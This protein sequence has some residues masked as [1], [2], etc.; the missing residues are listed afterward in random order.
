MFFT[1]HGKCY[2]V[3]VHEIP[4]GGR[5]AKGRHA[6]NMIKLDD[7]ESICAFQP[8]RRFEEGYYVVMGTRNGTIKKTELT[9][10]SN[11]RRDGIKAIGITPGEDELI[12]ASIT[13]GSNEVVLATRHGKAIRFPENK[14]RSMGRVAY[15][16]KGIN[17]EEDDYVV[18]MVVIKRSSW[19][20]T[21]TEN[22]Y[23]KRSSVDD[24]RITNR[25]GKGII[26]IKTSERNGEVVAVKEVVETDELMIITQH[27]I[28]IRTPIKQIRS[29]GRATQGVKLINLDEGDLVI[30]VARVVTDRNGAEEENG[31][32]L[33][34]SPEE[35]EAE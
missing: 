17:L 15:G 34:D 1:S 29:I 20:L 10:F 26:N 13:D 27:G 12:D 23:G 32:A 25:G 33:S 7:G 9:A 35:A 3:K 19:L 16:V 14:V 8:V 28:I 21:V 5:L 18:S 11:P 2:W 22:G 31:E 24:Y 6:T 30:D 4:V